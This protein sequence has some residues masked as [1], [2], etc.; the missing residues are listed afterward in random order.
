M[1]GEG[2]LLDVVGRHARLSAEE[3]KEAIL[4][5]VA[6]HTAGAAQSDDITLVVI[7]RTG[8]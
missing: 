3:I 1:F 8:G 4:A 6:R 7:K 5:A 2:A